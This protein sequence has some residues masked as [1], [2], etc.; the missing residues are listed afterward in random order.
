MRIG[1]FQF[2]PIFGD[3]SANLDRVEQAMSKI[4]CDIVV[5]PELFS[6]GYCFGSRDEVARLAENALE[7]PTVARLHRL[8]RSGGATIVAGVAEASGS[9]LYNS[10]LMVRP[11]GNTFVYRK[12]HL[13][14]REKEL[15]ERG[16]AASPVVAVGSAR[17]AVEVC[18]DYF[19]PELART[20][21]LA[22]AQVICHP[23]N[24]VLQYAQAMTVTRAQENRVFWV[25][26][27]RVGTEE[28]NG[29]R[30]TFTG[31]SQI[32]SPDGEV[33]FRAGVDEEILRIVEIDPSQADNKVVAGNDL[34]RD[35]RPEAYKEVMN[36]ER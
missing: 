10:C 12:I 28:A 27:N 20:V 1:L 9:A 5:L 18:F 24:L 30:L 22:G 36:A 14:N 7:G 4:E 15:F 6:T 2:A 3:K 31:Q 17:V 25:L 29:R 13:F 23:A 33:I 8:A 35:R 32:V 26:C 11:D 34:F 16:S 19:F 21:A